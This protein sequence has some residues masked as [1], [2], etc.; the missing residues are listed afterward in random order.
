VEEAP[1]H[2]YVFDLVGD[3]VAEVTWGQGLA[4]GIAGELCAL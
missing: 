3:V 2:W 1:G 4:E